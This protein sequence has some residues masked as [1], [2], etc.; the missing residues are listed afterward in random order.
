[1][2]WNTQSNI[3]GGIQSVSKQA[4]QEL[5]QQSLQQIKQQ[6]NLS[7]RK[8]H[9]I[10]QQKSDNDQ[11]FQQM[12]EGVLT[13]EQLLRFA[14][15]P[16]VPR[17]Y[18]NSLLQKIAPNYK[19]VEEFTD[20]DN[21][22]L[23]V[24]T[25]LN[26]KS[27]HLVVVPKG[28][29]SP[30]EAFLL[31]PSIKNLLKD[32]QLFTHDVNNDIN[33][34]NHRIPS[35]VIPVL[36]YF[37][38]IYNEYHSQIDNIDVTGFSLGGVLTQM[39]YYFLSTTLNRGDK[40]VHFTAIDSPYVFGI[41]E[42]NWSKIFN[43][44]LEVTT[45][46]E[47]QAHL[48]LMVHTLGIG[49]YGHDN[50]NKELI[51]INVENGISYPSDVLGFAHFFFRGGVAHAS[52]FI[53]VIQ[54]LTTQKVQ[55]NFEPI[56]D[57]PQG[58][59]DS[60]K[61]LLSPKY[62]DYWKPELRK[63][64]QEICQKLKIDIG[65]QD[66]SNAF[67]QF[68]AQFT[69]EYLSLNAWEQVDIPN[70]VSN[71]QRSILGY[72]KFMLQVLKAFKGTYKDFMTEYLAKT[73]SVEQSAC[74]KIKHYIEKGI[75]SI[76]GHVINLITNSVLYLIM[77]QKN[78]LPYFSDAQITEIV[79]SVET[80]KQKVSVALEKADQI[81]KWIPMGSFWQKQCV[82]VGKFAWSKAS[83]YNYSEMIKTL[84]LNIEKT[85]VPIEGHLTELLKF[86]E[87]LKQQVQSA[88]IGCSANELF[89]TQDYDEV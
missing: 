18:V 8:N 56:Q 75:H 7:A 38:K 14:M 27:R 6:Q 70:N 81:I 10:L 39:L 83:S 45:K 51:K 41:L 84:L 72:A 89:Q 43:E 50:Y 74:D 26:A 28:T 67:D 53:H 4:S 15:V 59:K 20:D 25:F 16:W 54:S 60:A 22:S 42:N 71:Y 33:I 61:F 88:F 78:P 11:G 17:Q 34:I 73:Y 82:N 57:W 87:H 85:G 31:D 46:I 69:K 76:Y 77:T 21:T 35:Q 2:A 32:V 65:Q 29:D 80:C 44:A 52:L 40:H 23:D 12:H 5:Y 19:L 63:G 86:P 13:H 49:S 66:A 79:T 58:L 1:M 48:T 36:L 3:E 9:L 62:A 47:Q 68:F 64:F 37:H 55:I 30:L 24:L